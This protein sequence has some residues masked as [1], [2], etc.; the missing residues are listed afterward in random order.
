MVAATMA[1]GVTT[2]RAAC[3]P[4][5][6]VHTFFTCSSLPIC[7]KRLNLNVLFSIYFFV[8]Y[9]SSALAGYGAAIQQQ[10]QM[11]THQQAPPQQQQQP[12]GYYGSA[13]GVPPGYGAPAGYSMYAAANGG[14]GAE[15]NGQDLQGGGRN[16]ADASAAS[17]GYAAAAQEQGGQG[18]Y[19]AYRGQGAAQGRVDRSYRPY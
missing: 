8:G 17:A 15:G 1:P 16:G 19:G 12:Q 14:A 5:S 9:D 18:Q 2:D 11:R 6:P 10:Q 4:T 3:P 7:S 13:A